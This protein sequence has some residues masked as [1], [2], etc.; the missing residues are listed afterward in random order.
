MTPFEV[1]L[2]TITIMGYLVGLFGSKALLSTYT[3]NKA[4]AWG[5]SV[6]SLFTLIGIGIFELYKCAL[7]D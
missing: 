1:F 5:L 4:L 6:F 2:S 3:D 7:D